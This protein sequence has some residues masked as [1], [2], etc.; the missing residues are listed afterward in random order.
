ML[1]AGFLI[2]NQAQ[3]VWLRWISWILPLRYAV[4]ATVINEFE[5][6]FNDILQDAKL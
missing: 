2:N 1:F 5:V 4:Q 3:Q 6:R